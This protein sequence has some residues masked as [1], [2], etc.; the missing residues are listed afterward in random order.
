MRS[1]SRYAILVVLASCTN[2]PGSNNQPPPLGG[3]LT[4]TGDVVDF[5]SGQP[6]SDKPDI[7]ITGADAAEV[8]LDGA[9]FT[10]K[11]VPYNTSFQILATAAPTYA[12]TYSPAIY[13][14]TSDVSNAKAYAVAASY[15]SQ[16]ATGFN[17]NASSSNGVV[18]MQIVDSSGVPKSGVAGSN[19]VLAGSTGASGPHFLDGSLA[20]STATSSSSSG[21]A[22]FFNVPVGAIALGQAA[23]ATVTLSMTESPVV[24]GTVTITTVTVT[25][26]APPPPPTN[27]SFSAQV[28]PIFTNRGCTACHSGNKIGANL[29]DLALDGGANH[30][31]MQLTNP[32]HPMII[33]TANP[34]KSL[35]LTMPS[36]ENPPDAHPNVI[37]TGPNDKDYQ[38]ILAWITEGAKNN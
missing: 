32:L 37:F 12:P 3:A 29:G 33:Q 6:I 28:V 31:Y 10:I 22:V 8:T 15:V 35:V 27:V 36:Y 4:I 30:V 25:S 17:V 20:P 1:Y 14:T 23:N 19:I 18:L 9:N 21:W 5:Q 38:T 2:T 26:G 11:D 16:L 7:Q 13:V 34:P 24:A